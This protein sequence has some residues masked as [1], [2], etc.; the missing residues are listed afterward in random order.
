M[1]E[2]QLEATSRTPAITLDPA[3]GRLVI[4]KREINVFMTCVFG[5]H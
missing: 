3:A 5:M 4:A 1:T 2:L